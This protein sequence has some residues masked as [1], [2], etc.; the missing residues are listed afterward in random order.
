MHGNTVLQGMSRQSRHAPAIEISGAAPSY[1]SP[2]SAGSPAALQSLRPEIKQM[3]C[4]AQ[5]RT[6]HKLW[7]GLQCTVDGGSEAMFKGDKECW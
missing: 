4:D 3:K 5:L 1:S 6:V 2:A 7:P